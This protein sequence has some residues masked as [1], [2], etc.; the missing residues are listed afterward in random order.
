MSDVK[1]VKNDPNSFIQSKTTTIPRAF[2]EHTKIKYI[3]YHTIEGFNYEEQQAIIYFHF[4][5]LPIKDIAKATDL[6]ENYVLS[7]IDLHLERL[8]SKINFFKKFVLH[9]VDDSLQVEDIF[10]RE[11]H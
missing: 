2:I 6:A 11:E 10:F 8:E 9:D 1:Q 4:L 3:L 7:A 5:K